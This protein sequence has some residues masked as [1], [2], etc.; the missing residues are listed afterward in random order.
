MHTLAL[1]VLLSLGVLVAQ[2]G[3]SF[4]VVSVKPHTPD[5]DAGVRVD[6][7]P[8]GRLTIANASLRM[9]ITFAYRLQD[10]QVVGGAEWTTTDRFDIVAK[11]EREA[12]TEELFVMLRPVLRDRFR[13]GL[14]N[15]TRDLP[16]YALTARSD[17]K[18]AGQRKPSD[19]DCTGLPGSGSRGCAFSVRAG[20]IHGRGMPMRRL[21][22]VLSQF[23]GRIVVDRTG[24]DSPQDF[25]LTW[26]PEFL[27][28]RQPPAGQTE[29]VL[30][31][32][33]VDP[34]GPSLFTALQE[35]LGLRLEST[36]APVDVL[37]I[38]RAEKPTAD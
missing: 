19:V 29:F 27:R 30:N 13:L 3:Q 32:L 16:V 20:S 33:S 15:A 23:A 1:A 35:Q 21:A 6:T 31:G 25:D 17:G 2:P 8:G 26:T 18:G 9:L 11:A 10:D 38:E 7:Q 24:L 37:A 12:T 14:Q 34:N 36:K 5:G 4:D 22:A 28:A